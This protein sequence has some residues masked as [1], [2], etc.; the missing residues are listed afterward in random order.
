MKDMNSPTVFYVV[1][2]IAVLNVLGYLSTKDWNS[3]TFFLLA[4]GLTYTVS[5]HRVLALVVGVVGAS[6][7][8]ASGVMHRE[9]LAT[10]EGAT[11]GTAPKATAAPAAP[12][13]PTAPAATAPPTKPAPPTGAAATVAKAKSEPAAEV[14]TAAPTKSSFVNDNGNASPV[15]SGFDNLKLNIEDQE[16]LLTVSKQMGPMVKNMNEMIKNL[17]DGFLEKAMASLKKNNYSLG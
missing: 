10:K 4:A 15:V 8:R 6:L 2:I 9:G 1:L 5:Q 11:T 3:L 14:P 12:A 13:A 16:K 17:P 7:F